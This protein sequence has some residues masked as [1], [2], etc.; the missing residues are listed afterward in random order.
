M[1]SPETAAHPT[2]ELADRAFGVE[3]WTTDPIRTYDEMGAQTRRAIDGLLPS[4][5]TYEGKRVL[6]FGCGAGRTLRQ[7]L[8]DAETAEIWG[9]DIDEAS[10]GWLQEN[11]CPPL[12]AWRAHA[13]PPLGL[14][15]GT[16]D[17]IWAVSVFTHLTSNST[18]W[19]LELHKLL[20][21]GGY[22]IPT[23]MGRWICEFFT[24]EPWNEDRH[25]RTMLRHTWPWDKGGP[26][27]LISDWW[28]REHWGRAF[29]IV[30]VT[31]EV[32]NMTWPLLR[33][34]NVELTTA[35]IDEPADDPREYEALLTNLRLLRRE[36]ALIEKNHR[37]EA[38]ALEARVRAEYEQSTS[39][40]VTAPV[41]AAAR[42]RRA[43]RA[44]Q[45]DAD[46]PSAP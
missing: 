33:K 36:I 14:E 11:L 21:P 38:E 24:G 5:W 39:W 18:A 42:R 3:C 40:R 19:L 45:A 17:L 16:F 30:D 13:L 41:R 12:N 8:P 26:G 2:P 25:G 1:S 15:H 37:Q 20:K 9:T 28:M 43:R 46:A 6:D 32:H 44:A 27:V 7:F 34:R 29:E 10:I 35:D 4:D 31:A 22:L 23:Y